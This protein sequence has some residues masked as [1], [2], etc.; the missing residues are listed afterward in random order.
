MA[1]TFVWETTMHK[2]MWD[3]FFLD[4]GFR[5]LTGWEGKRDHKGITEIVTHALNSFSD[6]REKE[7]FLPR[8]SRRL[9]CLSKTR[10]PRILAQKDYTNKQDAKK[11]DKRKQ[12]IDTQH[13]LDYFSILLKTL[14]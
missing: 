1:D 12:R 5:E 7:R 11:T 10:K 3:L 2:G 9:Y 6:G 4:W 13:T 14:L 8:R